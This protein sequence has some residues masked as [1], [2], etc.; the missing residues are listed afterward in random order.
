MNAIVAVDKDWG[1]GKEGKLL[2]YLPGD[3]NYYKEKTLNKTI[4]IGRKTLESFP[5]GLPLPRRENII[6]TR[7][8]NMCKKIF[9]NRDYKFV[10]SEEELYEKLEEIDTKDIFVSGGEE[11]YKKLLPLCDK[12]YVTKINEKFQAD[13]FFPNLDYMENFYVSWQGEKEEE[14]GIEYQFLI[15]EKRK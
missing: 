12:V 5:K 14:N 7:N 8:K 10:F 2:C 15:Y 11:I 1:I 13:A 6:L 4:V 9:E 3:L